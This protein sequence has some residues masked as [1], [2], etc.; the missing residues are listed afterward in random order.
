MFI[1]KKFKVFVDINEEERYLNE[2]A[3]RGYILKK[4][5]C[6][7]RYHF[8]EGKPE[9]LHYRVDYRVFKMCI[10]DRNINATCNSSFIFNIT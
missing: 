2:M 5:S 4:Y 8:I 1:M 6:F 7:G 10:R 3:N 9:D